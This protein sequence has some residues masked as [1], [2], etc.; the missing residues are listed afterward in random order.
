MNNMAGNA[1]EA[2]DW[3]A[4]ARRLQRQQ[5]HQL[6]QQGELASQISAFIA[7]NKLRIM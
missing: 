4:R 6:A 2:G 5:L 3:F 1:P 7:E